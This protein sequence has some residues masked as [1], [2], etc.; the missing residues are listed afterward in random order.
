[1]GRRPA[2]RFGRPPIS[3]APVGDRVLPVAV[4]GRFPILETLVGKVVTTMIRLSTLCAYR[5]E[6]HACG[7]S[8]DQSD[9]GS[10]SD[11]KRFGRKDRLRR[12]RG[13]L[14]YLD[15]RELFTGVPIG[16]HLCICSAADMCFQDLGHLLELV[17][18]A[19]ELSCNG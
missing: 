18:Q 10:Q 9:D 12:S 5:F 4:L 3:E 19:T 7:C 8:A 1:M 16:V 2:I 11:E 15:I 6:H 17:F 14:S 13:G